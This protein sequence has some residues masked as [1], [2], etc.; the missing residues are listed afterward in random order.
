MDKQDVTG[1]VIK[2]QNGDRQAQQDLYIHGSKSVFYT[3]LKILRN[4][5]DA[6]DITQDVFLTVYE[7]LP[8]L[9]KP[10]AYYGWVNQILINKCMGFLRKHKPMPTDEDILDILE[11]N[12][13]EDVNPAKILDDEEARKII[14]DIIDTLPDSQR[15]CIISRYFN[16]LSIGEI[17]EISGT[18]EHTV[19]SRLALARKKIRKAIME[20]EE[21]DGIRLHA[22]F[23]IPIMPVLMKAFDEYEMPDGLQAR[24]WENISA[25]LMARSKANT[26]EL[27]QTASGQPNPMS[28]G[29]I[30]NAVLGSAGKGVASMM[31]SKAIAIILSIIGG[32]AVITAV[33][34]YYPQISEMFSFSNMGEIIADVTRDEATSPTSNS[35]AHNSETSDQQQGQ[36]ET[37]TQSPTDIDLSEGTYEGELDENGLFAGWGVWNYYN[38]RY[39]G[40]FENGMPN[41]KGTFT[42]TGN[43]DADVVLTIIQ[44][45]W[46]DGLANNEIKYT[47]HAPYGEHRENMQIDTFVFEVANG[48]PT[49]NGEV[50]AIETNMDFI[51]NKILSTDEI[52]SVPPWI[53]LYINY[54]NEP[55]TGSGE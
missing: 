28:A 29:E 32:A 10:E 16:Q 5:E 47:L 26:S 54:S 19:K 12:E 48:H 42:I 33:V 36:Q 37:D 17:A 30:Q 41:G 53:F 44:G 46:I 34:I 3:A 27:T 21:R 22:L 51:P 13:N 7:K 52:F 1:L 9:R 4:R 2:A 18:N 40:Y 24:M 11:L 39:E 23:P 8:E 6:E 45:I 50:L 35:E 14:M 38:T 43:A 25:S 31:S 15:F 55:P 20:K 49:I